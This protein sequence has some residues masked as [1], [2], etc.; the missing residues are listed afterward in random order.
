MQP[1]VHVD[2]E[3]VDQGAGEHD[4]GERELRRTQNGDTSKER[5]RRNKTCFSKQC[6]TY[7]RHYNDECK[8][9]GRKI[10]ARRAVQSGLVN[11]LR[12]GG[13]FDP[14]NGPEKLVS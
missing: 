12:I 6:P 2:P 7:V 13:E 1:G 4:E 9:L 8:F 10:E 11:I 14:A 5:R 3:H